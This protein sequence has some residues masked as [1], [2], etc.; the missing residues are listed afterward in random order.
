MCTIEVPELAEPLGY[1]QRIVRS[2]R[3]DVQVQEPSYY[4]LTDEGAPGGRI[5]IELVCDAGAF[6]LCLH[7]FR[8]ACGESCYRGIGLLPGDDDMHYWY[9]TPG[10]RIMKVGDGEKKLWA[11]RE[12]ASGPQIVLA[13]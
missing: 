13:A 7:D 2:H 4:A 8:V 11:V 1:I 5:E 9:V 10:Q 3:A 12:P 6:Y